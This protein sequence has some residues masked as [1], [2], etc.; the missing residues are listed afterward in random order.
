[1]LN[2]LQPII[3]CGAAPA[4]LTSVENCASS[5]ATSVSRSSSCI[6]SA[7]RQAGEK[8]AIL[9]RFPISGQLRNP[10]ASAGLVAFRRRRRP[11]LPPRL[12]LFQHLTDGNNPRLLEY[13]D[14][15]Q[16]VLVSSDEEVGLTGLCHRE[17]EIVGRIRRSLDKRQR[18]DECREFPKLIGFRAMACGF[19][20]AQAAPGDDG[21]LQPVAA[22]CRL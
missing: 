13:S 1:M 14:R 18:H 11:S 12:D 8:S 5:R 4:A 9:S 10:R 6:R 22:A 20:P 21:G 16:I 7:R 15:K 17:E 2:R 19:P 3:L